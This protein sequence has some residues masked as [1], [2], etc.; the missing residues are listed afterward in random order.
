MGWSPPQFDRQICV[1]VYIY[2]Y[3]Y[4]YTLYDLHHRELVL[5]PPGQKTGRCSA[6]KSGHAL[7]CTKHVLSHQFPAWD[8]T[9]AKPRKGNEVVV[10]GKSQ[11]SEAPEGSKMER[12][13]DAPSRTTSTRNARLAVSFGRRGSKQFMGSW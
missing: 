5:P 11:D 10:A 8:A 12:R 7:R 2:I 9:Q 6:D 1:C 13:L 4:I 3:I